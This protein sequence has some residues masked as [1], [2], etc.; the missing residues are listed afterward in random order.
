LAHLKSRVRTGA[1]LT[2]RTRRKKKIEYC[3]ALLSSICVK[4]SSVRTILIA[5]ALCGTVLSSSARVLAATIQVPAGGDLQQAIANAQPGDTIV[6]SP[7][8][9]YTGT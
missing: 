4:L 1:L 3:R 9:T 2:L 5:A 6:L 8:A 7:G